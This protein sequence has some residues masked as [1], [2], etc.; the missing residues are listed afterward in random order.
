LATTMVELRE[1]NPR[2]E[3]FKQGVATWSS[4]RANCNNISDFQNQV[5]N[6]NGL[7]FHLHTIVDFLQMKGCFSLR[8]T[9]LRLIADIN[10]T[11]GTLCS[12]DDLVISF[13]DLGVQWLQLGYSGK[14]GL[15][16]DR[17]ATYCARNGTTP[18]VN[19]Q[20][21][22]SRCQYLLVTGNLDKLYAKFTLYF[23]WDADT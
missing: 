4:M 12:P 7:V 10:E 15:A 9:L 23:R 1:E 18:Y 11:C 20:M 6:I 14:A 19:L 3:V 22:L 2:I 5:E 17:A 21:H 13:N 16:F 8:V